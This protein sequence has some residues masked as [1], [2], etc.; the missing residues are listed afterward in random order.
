[1]PVRRLAEQFPD[2]DGH[3]NRCETGIESLFEEHTLFW[4]KKQFRKTIYTA[5]SGLPGCLFNTGYSRLDA[6]TTTIEAAYHNTIH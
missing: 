4:N 5:N 1:M 3:V 2:M 6:Y